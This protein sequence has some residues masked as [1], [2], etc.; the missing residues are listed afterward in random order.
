M[1]FISANKGIASDLNTEII[2]LAKI[3]KNFMFRNSPSEST[4]SQLGYISSPELASSKKFITETITTDNKLTTDEFLKLP[5]EQTLK[6]LYIIRRVN[7]NLSEDVPMDNV[8]LIEDLS[9]KEISRYERID[10]Y[11]DMLFSGVGNKNRPFDLSEIN[12]EPFK[13]DLKDDTEK[14]IFFFKAMDLCGMT[15]WG[16]MNIV[17]PPNYKAAKEHIDNYPKFNGQPYYQYSD[18]GFADFEMEI[19]QGKGKESYKSYYLDRYYDTL[20]SHLQCLAQKKKYKEA[21]RDL[22]LGSILQSENYY[23]YSKKKELLESLFTT[24]EK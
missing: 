24:V 14:A 3:Y 10:S 8:E 1:L 9:K 6:Y 21:R 15:I 20:L 11:Y 18:F 23:K 4:F 2:D 12:F 7:W 17:K 5:D 19:E 16:Y 13:Y 22:L